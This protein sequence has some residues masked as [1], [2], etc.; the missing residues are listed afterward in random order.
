MI[1]VF[2]TSS[3]IVI[4]HYFPNSFPTFWE[5]FDAAVADGRI[6]S[7]R[8]V[9]N[10]LKRGDSPAHLASWVSSN[11]GIFLTPTEEETQVVA[12]IFSVSHF[13]QIVTARQLLRG[14]P[15]ADPFLVAS[16]KAKGGCVV[17]QEKV[18]KNAARIPNVCD[19][20]GVRWTD[21]EGF[22]EAEHWRF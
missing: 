7:V 1:Y 10:E 8:E 5:Q 22:M 6:V 2:D 12:D 9:L 15:V 18:K 11:K 21:L 19:H 16:A 17:T 20:L 4:G 3:F 13:R 14:T